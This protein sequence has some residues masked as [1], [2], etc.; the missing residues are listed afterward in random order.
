MTGRIP[1]VL[2]QLSNENMMILHFSGTVL[3]LA[4]AISFQASVNNSV[5]FF[6][7]KL[8]NYKG[9]MLF[10]KNIWELRPNSLA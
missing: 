4:L 6:L 8:M 9:N 3:A 2:E 5:D 10:L 1:H 7:V